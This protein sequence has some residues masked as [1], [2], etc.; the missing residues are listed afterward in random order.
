MGHFKI[1]SK[2]NLDNAQVGDIISESAY[3]TLTPEGNFVQLEYIQDEGYSARKYK[4]EPG[5]FTIFE[6]AMGYE[7]KKT[8]YVKDKI[9]SSFNNTAK[10][11]DSINMFF[12]KLHV[13]REHGIEIPRRAALVWGPAG[14]GKTSSIIDT[15][16]SYSSDGKTAI[17]LWATDKHEAGYVKDF[18]ASFEYHGVERLI[19]VAEDIGGIEIDEGK[20]RSDSSLLSLLDNQEK[21]FSVPVYII[22]TTNFPEIFLGNLTNRPG[23]FDDKIEVGYPNANQRVQLLNFFC[24]NTDIS[25][26]AAEL[27]SSKYSEFSIAHIKELVLR[28]A[29]YDKDLSLVLK[30]MIA[31]IEQYKR[32]FSKRESMGF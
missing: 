15:I 26:I 2:I 28:A 20:M 4:V 1:K 18:I 3:A 22:G 17:I 12:N 9:L 32:A 10:V 5:I 29:V 23:R 14:T 6:T 21:T 25:D 30:E 27:K 7:L 8:E 24:K 16:S 13:Y 31:E 11:R 19:L